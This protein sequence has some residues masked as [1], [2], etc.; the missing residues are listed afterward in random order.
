MSNKF[1]KLAVANFLFAFFGAAAS[2][3]DWFTMHQGN[4]IV[5]GKAV[6]TDNST[7]TSS[8]KLEKYFKPEFD[9]QENSA[10]F[11]NTMLQSCHVPP[12]KFLLRTKKDGILVAKRCSEE[13]P[14]ARDKGALNL[15][16]YDV[17]RNE[18]GNTK[19]YPLMIILSKDMV[20]L[21]CNNKGLIDSIVTVCPEITNDWKLYQPLSKEIQRS[22][23]LNYGKNKYFVYSKRIT[24]FLDLS[25]DGII[26]QRCYTVNRLSETPAEITLEISDFINPSQIILSSGNFWLPIN[27]ISNALMLFGSIDSNTAKLLNE[28]YIESFKNGTSIE[29]AQIS[30]FNQRK[31]TEESIRK[32]ITQK[33]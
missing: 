10:S 1:I 22:L 32:M 26:S 29:D 4:T 18:E 19:H 17:Y 20:S 5:L 24:S 13:A 16:F 2:K 30:L 12:I 31:N 23:K 15:P 3:D 25:M 21:T 33:I 14:Q 28:I 6:N 9:V 27:L 11:H 8:F 7:D